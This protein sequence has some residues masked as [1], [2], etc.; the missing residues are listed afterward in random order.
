MNNVLSCLPIRT[1]AGIRIV[2]HKDTGGPIVRLLLPIV[3]ECKDQAATLSSLQFFIHLLVLKSKT[4]T[5]HQFFTL[6]GG[7][8]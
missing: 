6:G 2:H 3:D 8:Q 1:N 4:K 5:A 7:K